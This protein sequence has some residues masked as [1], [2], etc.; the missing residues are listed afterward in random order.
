M[1]GTATVTFGRSGREV[2]CAP[3]TT[4]LAAAQQAGVSLPSSCGGGLCGTCKSGLLA[5]KVEMSHQGGI[6]P[7]EVAAGKFLPC[8]STPD[9]DIV[10][11]A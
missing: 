6:R 10:V 8:C 11:D 7:R 1:P 2:V 4:V 3:G 5:G 9:G